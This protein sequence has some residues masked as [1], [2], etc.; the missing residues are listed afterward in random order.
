M[1]AGFDR[2][3]GEVIVAMDGDLQN[4]PSDIPRLMEELEKGFD[5]VSGWRKDR[6]DEAIRRDC[7]R[8]LP[9]GSSAS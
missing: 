5:V 8:C 6:K 7:L 1:S 4:D 3:K 9:T 2:A